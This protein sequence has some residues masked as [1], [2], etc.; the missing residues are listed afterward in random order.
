MRVECKRDLA[1]VLRSL[2]GGAQNGRVRLIRLY[3]EL[4]CS[5]EAFVLAVAQAA[6]AW[7]ELGTDPRSE[8]GFQIEG[9]WYT[10]AKIR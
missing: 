6:R 9:R 8:T 10:W 5:T 2:S 3:L 1:E 4:G 7:L